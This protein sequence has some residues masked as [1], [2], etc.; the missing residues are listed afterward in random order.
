[1]QYGFDKETYTSNIG[2]KFAI[3]LDF[4]EVLINS[5]KQECDVKDSCNVE[6][7][8]S[9]KPEKYKDID[10]SYFDAKIFLGVNRVRPG[11][12]YFENEEDYRNYLN[13]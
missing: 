3:D 9:M 12:H 5:R 10:Y 8:K 13:L 1:M 11:E 2:L 4:P 7:S 6:G